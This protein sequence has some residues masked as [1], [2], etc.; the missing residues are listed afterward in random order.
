MPSQPRPGLSFEGRADTT[1]K[2]V[3]RPTLW[4]FGRLESDISI[5]FFFNVF[6]FWPFAGPLLAGVAR[7]SALIIW[8]TLINIV[9]ADAYDS[10]K[11]AR[12][13]V[14]HAALFETAETS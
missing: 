12:L 7:S 5:I 14:D 6:F 1:I 8:R 3:T 9:V 13:K 4:V 2:A 11:P 10:L